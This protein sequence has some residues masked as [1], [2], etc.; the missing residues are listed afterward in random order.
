MTLGS[1]PPTYRARLFGSGAA[2]RIDPPALEGDIK[3]PE[4][5][6]IG[7]VIAVGIGLLFWG[8][9]TGGS[10]GGGICAGLPWPFVA[11]LP[12]SGCPGAPADEGGGGRDVEED[13]GVI[14]AI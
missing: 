8:M 7:D 10:G 12:K 9:T 13:D 4:K 1:K 3:P 2:R 11:E 14:S 6:D 5:L